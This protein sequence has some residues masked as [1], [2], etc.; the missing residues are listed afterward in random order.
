VKSS[1]LARALTLNVALLAL[2]RPTFS[3]ADTAAGVIVGVTGH[4]TVDRQAGAAIPATL[5]LRL[6]AVDVVVVERGASAEIYLKGGGVVRLHDATRFA[7]PKAV[8]AEAQNVARARLKDGSIAQLE[9]GLWVLNDPKGSLLVSPM[10]GD[11][12]WSSPADAA[13]PLTP[14]YEALTDTHVAF[15]WSGGPARAR[16]VIAKRREAIWKSEPAPAGTL[17]D[18]GAALRLEAG[19][20]YTWWLEPEAGGPPLTAGMPFRV[21]EQAIIERTKAIE[22]ELRALNGAGSDTAAADYLRVAHYAG[23]GSWTHVLVLAGGMEAGNARTRA[24]EAATRGLRLDDPGVAQL[25][26]GLAHPVH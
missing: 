13:V 1:R 25:A 5:G 6:D 21:A 26:A 10:R 24:I 7:M 23:A 2:V 12:A 18:P 3:A 4:V 19:E 11:G 9:S 22:E 17:L 15:L 20:V 16:V 14:R 8:G